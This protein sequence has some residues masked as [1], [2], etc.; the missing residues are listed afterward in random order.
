MYRFLKH[1]ADILF[2]VE[3]TSPDMLFEDA[4][5]AVMATMAD[6]KSVKPKIK[7]TITVEAIA[8]DDLLY[9]FLSELIYIKDAE[10]MLFSRCKVKIMPNK[11]V[12]KDTGIYVEHTNGYKLIAEIFGE[13]IDANKH[14]LGVDV[15][16]VT[17]HMFNVEKKL[18]GKSS[19][20]NKRYKWYAKVL[21]DV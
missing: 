13:K 8:I 18:L 16:A 17:M 2:E 19:A 21:L 14:K 15:K 3:A 4:G 1:T 5:K 11:M 9:N 6:L 20:K 12:Q 7:K 10:F